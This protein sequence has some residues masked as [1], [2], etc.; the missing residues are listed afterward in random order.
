MN[1]NAY[2]DIKWIAVILSGNFSWPVCPWPKG[3]VL[4]KVTSFSDR[5]L[6][7]TAGPNVYR[8]PGLCDILEEPFQL[9]TFP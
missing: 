2:L 6:H 9:E 5:I 8:G 1:R 7:P 3:T 4:L